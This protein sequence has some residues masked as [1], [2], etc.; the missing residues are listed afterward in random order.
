MK[1]PQNIFATWKKETL[2][3]D[4]LL[5]KMAKL[6]DQDEIVKETKDFVMKNGMNQ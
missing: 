1:G 5:K 4:R 3:I 2:C 6:F